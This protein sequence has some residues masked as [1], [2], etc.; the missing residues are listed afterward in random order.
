VAWEFLTTPGRR[1]SWQFQVTDVTVTGTTGGRRGLGSTNHCM[2]GEDAVIEEILDWRP[3]D[4]VTDRTVLDTP[5][6]PVKLP[7]TIEFEPTTTGTTVHMRFAAPKTKRE[8][9]LAQQ[10][11]DAYGKALRGAVPEL[12]AQLDAVMKAR[13]ADR[14]PEPDVAKPSPAGPLAGIQP[15]VMID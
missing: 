14:G 5:A 1:K 3:Y 10:L 11:G 6:G 12:V 8:Q 2:H 9:V 7:H 4:Y 13:N 15:L